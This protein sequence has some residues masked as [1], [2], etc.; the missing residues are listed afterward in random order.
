MSIIF[1]KTYFKL[2]FDKNAIIERYDS[3]S[4][5]LY[6]GNDNIEYHIEFFK[7]GLNAIIKKW[8]QNN[9]KESPEEIFNIIKEEYKNKSVIY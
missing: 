1:Y 2:G 3:A 8:L 5:S 4:A 9:C 6:Y 7:A